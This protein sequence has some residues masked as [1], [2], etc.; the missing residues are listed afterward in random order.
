MRENKDEI[1]AEEELA[2]AM[3]WL[4][5]CL[6]RYRSCRRMDPDSAGQRHL[7]AVGHELKFG[8]CIERE[9]LERPAAMDTHPYVSQYEALR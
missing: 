2:Q 1:R 6:A 8:C 9:A 3:V 7:Y 5:V 4:R